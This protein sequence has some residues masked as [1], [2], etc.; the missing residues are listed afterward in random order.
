MRNRTSDLRIPHSD[1]LPLSHRDS[2]VSEA[3]YKV[4]MTRVLHTARIS[5][6]DSIMF[7][8]RNKT[9]SWQD[10]KTSI[11]VSLPSSKF[12]ISL[13]S[14][15]TLSTSLILAVCRTRVFMNFVIGLAHRGV[16][17][18][19]WQSIGVRNPKVWGS[20]PHWTQNFSLIPRSWKDEKNLS[21]FSK[22]EVAH[23]RKMCRFT[24]QL[25]WLNVE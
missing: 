13:I 4:H 14:I 17:V 24:S 25:T 3:Y 23:R 5:N 7:V 6:V 10:K 11:F 16:S 1:A 18:A 22:F 19:Q 8:D 2:T 21:L 12:T 15:I 20:I 9:R